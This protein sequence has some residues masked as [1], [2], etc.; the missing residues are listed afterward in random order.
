MAARKIG[1]TLHF[2]DFL[3]IHECASNPCLNGA[4]CID[5][6]GSYICECKDGWEG[7]HCEAGINEEVVK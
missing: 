4:T 5:G 3:D 6:V 7:S 2:Y 1:D